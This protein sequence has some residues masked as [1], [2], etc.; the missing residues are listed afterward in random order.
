MAG[1]WVAMERPGRLKG[2]RLVIGLDMRSNRAQGD[3]R[4]ETLNIIAEAF[5]ARTNADF[6]GINVTTSRKGVGPDAI[7]RVRFIGEHRMFT[8]EDLGRLLASPIDVPIIAYV[9]QLRAQ[10]DTESSRG[11]GAICRISDRRGHNKRRAGC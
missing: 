2:R 3:I 1:C 6:D 11:G 10:S 9:N 4:D 7:F 8:N 5:D